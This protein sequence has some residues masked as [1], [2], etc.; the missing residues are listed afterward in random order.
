MSTRPGLIKA[1]SNLVD[2]V[3]EQTFHFQDE[4]KKSSV[5]GFTCTVGAGV[6]REY[7][8]IQIGGMITRGLR[9][10]LSLGKFLH[11]GS[12]VNLCLW[13]YCCSFVTAM[14]WGRFPRVQV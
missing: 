7:K 14:V 10:I 13:S 9:D 1:G 12:E 5:T 3:R 2:S 8:F 6:H 4:A 11:C